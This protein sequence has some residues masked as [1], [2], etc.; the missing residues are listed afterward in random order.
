MGF[1]L[2]HAIVRCTDKA[3]AA[4][5]FADLIGAAPVQASGPFAAVRVND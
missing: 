5:F 3:G 1:E 4:Q 2:N